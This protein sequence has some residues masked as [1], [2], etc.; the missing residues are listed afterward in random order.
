MTTLGNLAR[1]NRLLPACSASPDA[2]AR[3]PDTGSGGRPRHRLGV[4]PVDARY[5]ATA[6]HLNS[7][8]L[9]AHKQWIDEIKSLIALRP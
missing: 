5:M 9:L 4:A 1:T 7:L 3:R 8:R 2:G 6:I